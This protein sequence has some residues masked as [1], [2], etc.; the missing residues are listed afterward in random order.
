MK[1]SDCGPKLQSHETICLSSLKVSYVR[2][3]F[4][5]SKRKLTNAEVPKTVRVSLLGL[6]DTG[7][8]ILHLRMKGFEI[9]SREV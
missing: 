2:C 6:D 1:S 7:C 8:D 4:F 3:V 5:L 9:S